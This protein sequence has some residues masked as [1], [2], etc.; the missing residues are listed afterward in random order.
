RCARCARSNTLRAYGRR[1]TGHR[2]CPER[3]RPGAIYNIADDNPISFNE[4][5]GAAAQAIGAPAPSSYPR[6][7]VHLLAP[8]AVATATSRIPIS[9]ARAKRELGWTPQFPSYR[10]GL[11]Q[12]VQRVP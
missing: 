2:R 9:N 7:L 4:F 1:R 10:E 11:A 6:W 12:V 5:V 3:G 8:A